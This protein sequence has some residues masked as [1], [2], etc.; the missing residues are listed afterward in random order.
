MGKK[1]LVIAPHPDDETLGC[2]G[3]LLRHKKNGDSIYWLIVTNIAPGIRWREQQ[4]QKRQAEIQK[5]SKMYGFTETFKLDFPAAQL[6]EVPYG[7]LV[8]KIASVINT[9]MPAVVYVPNHSDIH[10]DHLVTFRASLSC[11]KDF[12]APFIERVLMYECLSETEFAPG[13]K[14]YGFVPN[15]FF[16]VTPFFERKIKIFKK[17]VSEVMPSPL[18]RSLEAVFHL[19]RFRGHRIG[20]KHAEAFCLLYE[21]NN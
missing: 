1:V 13:I 18:P 17:Y 8:S 5:V 19:S 16:D 6:D 15:V 12:R 9:V 14:E 7:N 4:V 20:R 3:T 2:G 11:C 10:T 21:K